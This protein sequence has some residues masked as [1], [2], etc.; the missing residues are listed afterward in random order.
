MRT[1]VSSLATTRAARKMAFALSAS[2]LNRGVRADEHV[3]QR[4]LAHAEPERV[5]EQTAQPLVGKRLEALEV[6]RQRMNA[7]PERRRCRHR[8]RRPFHSPR[9]NARIGRR[10]ADGG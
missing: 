9:R 5:E 6:D 3:H 7:R 4:A 1:P 8:R 2:I 10:T